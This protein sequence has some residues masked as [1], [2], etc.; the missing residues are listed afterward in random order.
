MC[1][2][3]KNVKASPKRENGD[4]VV[5]IVPQTGLKLIVNQEWRPTPCKDNYKVTKRN[6]YNFQELAK[7]PSQ[8]KKIKIRRLKVLQTVSFKSNKSFSV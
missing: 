4:V 8:K 5:T 7:G 1:V 6:N 3:S 2:E